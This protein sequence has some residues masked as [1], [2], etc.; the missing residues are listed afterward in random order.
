MGCGEVLLRAPLPRI[1]A[2]SLLRVPMK[3]LV[4]ISGVAGFDSRRTAI[5][6]VRAM[7]ALGL[8]VVQVR[9]DQAPSSFPEG[10]DIVHLYPGED[11]TLEQVTALRSCAPLVLLSC[12]G[13]RTEEKLAPLA[14]LV[15]VPSRHALV[16]LLD[17][18]ALQPGRS[19]ILF[20]GSLLARRPSVPDLDASPLRLLHIGVRGPESGLEDLARVL[21][22]VPAGLVELDCFGPETGY[23][24][25]LSAL[26]GPAQVRCHP[27]PDPASLASLAVG[28]H[29]AVFPW[30]S[31]DRY[32][33]GVDDAFALGIPAWVAGGNAVRERHDASSFTSLPLGDMDAWAE[34]LETWLVEPSHL[35]K[36]YEILPDRVPRASDA[37]EVL[38][39]WSRELIES[40]REPDQPPYRRPA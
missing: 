25:R 2:H 12:D 3:V 26:A 18:V 14:D 11:T 36:A 13:D 8:E 6:Q 4:A 37:A 27:C 30:R 33:L 22:Q 38:V 1:Q 23:D 29:L 7:E 28:A 15:V 17:R 40:S 35:H 31:P 24:T 32:A 19:R 5:A 21:S 34:K 10:V 16:H 39:R 20:P 9:P